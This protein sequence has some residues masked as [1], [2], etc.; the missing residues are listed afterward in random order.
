[1]TNTTT[2]PEYNPALTLTEAATYTPG[3]RHCLQLRLK[4]VEFWSTVADIID[5]M[6]FT[7]ILALATHWRWEYGEYRVVR[8]S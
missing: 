2:R 8:V 4:G 5:E 7:A 1:M 3:R 6:D